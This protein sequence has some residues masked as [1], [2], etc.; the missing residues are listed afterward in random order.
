VNNVKKLIIGAIFLMPI[1]SVL[2][3]ELLVG[4]S[5]GKVEFNNQETSD[6]LLKMGAYG[7]QAYIESEDKKFFYVLMGNVIGKLDLINNKYMG[8]KELK[9]SANEYLVPLVEQ[10]YRDICSFG[11][12][13]D[14]A[15]EQKLELSYELNPDNSLGCFG[16]HPLRYGDLDGDTTDEIVLFLGEDIV[17]FSPEQE[18]ITFSQNLNVA[19]WMS[20]EE[21]S[22]WIIDFGKAGPL[23]DQHPQYQS[24]I[25]A[26]TS[27]N[28]QSVQPAYR[29]YGKLYFG[30]FNS[31]GKR[32][33]IVWRKIY[34]SLLRGDSKKGFALKE[35]TYLHYEKPTS[36]IYELIGTPVDSVSNWLAS[37][38]LTWQ[39]GYPSKSECEGQ[40][41]Q[42]IPEMHDPLLNDPDLLK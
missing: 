35:D 29:G 16:N 2:S 39:K 7:M 21:T 42:L 30:D 5:R 26:F 19:D 23:D 20:K 38:G 15:S 24:S 1:E 31:D 34:E 12:F 8:G 36:G 3:I 13:G 27:A 32:D 40:E 4:D 28:Y 37:R 6:A 11:C 25:V 10:R 41:G 18:A 9:K 22:L 17:M 33:I 14:D